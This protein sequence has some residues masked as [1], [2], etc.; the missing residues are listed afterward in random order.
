MSEFQKN[1]IEKF[2]KEK[3]KSKREL[4]SFL[5]IKEN[6]INRTLKNPNISFG[7]LGKIAEFLEMDVREFFPANNSVNIQDSKSEYA[8]NLN[9]MNGHTIIANLSEVLKINSKT[10]EMMA[11][12]EKANA[13]NIEN[14]VKILT[15]KILSDKA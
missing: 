10:I 12:T 11:E 13:R 15:E 6:S 7:K 14:L 4:A 2:L 5:N 3:K 8:L 1:I 9:E